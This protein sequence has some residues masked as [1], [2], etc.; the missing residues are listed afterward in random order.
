[1]KALIRTLAVIL[2]LFAAETASAQTF[3]T[4]PAQSVIGRLGSSPGR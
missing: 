3:P 4:I 1:M 2:A